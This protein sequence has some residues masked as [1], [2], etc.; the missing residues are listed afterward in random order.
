MRQRSP[1]FT[2]VEAMV[3]VAIVAVLAG[4]GMPAMSNW[5]LARK[6]AAA[7]DF[8]RDGLLTARNQA[9]MHNSASRMILSP[10]PDNGQ[11]EWRVDICYPTTADRCSA[12]SDNWSS[13]VDAAGG[14]PAGAAGYRS[15]QR[16]SAGLPGPDALVVTVAP[17]EAGAVYFGP[18]GWVD[19]LVTPRVGR[20][21]I[22]PAPEREAAFRP[23]AVALTLAGVT[24]LCDP[25]AA[26]AAARACP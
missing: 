17:G 20:I 9:L 24:S 6:A 23:L 26:A 22:A 19:T 21:V 1:G 18:V 25:A 8:Y 2:A 11:P 15:V 12:T 4:I 7:A 14:D 13:V 16:S 5:L 3:V 10:N